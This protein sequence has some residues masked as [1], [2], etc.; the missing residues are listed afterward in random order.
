MALTAVS[1][2]LRNEVRKDGVH[3]GIAYVGFTEN[4]PEKIIYDAD[5]QLIYLEERK[6]MKKQSPQ[7]VA[8]IIRK[9]ILRRQ[10]K[11]VLS[12]AGKFLYI[13]NRL[14]PS[15]ISRIFYSRIDTIKANSEGKP[16]YVKQ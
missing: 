16:R 12:P 4:D 2:S 8:A 11:K 6:G 1:E 14:F 15:L 9:M 3:V 5:G 7:Q 13:A 10:A